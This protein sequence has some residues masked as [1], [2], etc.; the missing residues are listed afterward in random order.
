MHYMGNVI[1][2]IPC[3][4]IPVKEFAFPKYQNQ[5]NSKSHDMSGQI[6]RKIHLLTSTRPVFDG[7]SCR[8]MYNKLLRLLIICGCGL[9]TSYKWTCV[10]KMKTRWN[11]IQKI[12]HKLQSHT[13]MHV[14][15]RLVKSMYD[16]LLKLRTII[17]FISVCY[18]QNYRWRLYS[19]ESVILTKLSIPGNIKIMYCGILIK[20]PYL[21][22][23]LDS[24][25]RRLS[26]LLTMTYLCLSVSTDKY[27]FLC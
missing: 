11:R 21:K 5:L 22:K 25:F 2:F 1:L 20:I 7:W 17:N 16:T 3:A 14:R 18:F 8:A 23:I 10:R 4:L 26:C 13:C 6:T 19:C 12:V 15:R 24:G 9:Q 27:I